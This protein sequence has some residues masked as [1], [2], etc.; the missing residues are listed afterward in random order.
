M[1]QTQDNIR[2]HLKQRGGV[3]PIMQRF[4]NNKINPRELIPK[5]KDRIGQGLDRDKLTV[6]AASS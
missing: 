6:S 2:S 1:D 5:L 4:K 3:L